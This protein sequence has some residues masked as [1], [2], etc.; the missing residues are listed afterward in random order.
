MK[1]RELVDQVPATYSQIATW[2]NNGVKIG[3]KSKGEGHHKQYDELDVKVATVLS[4]LSPLLGSGKRV[5]A[6]R[7]IMK[8]VATQ[9]RKEPAIAERP[10]IYITS[11]GRIT[12][13]PLE[14]Y[15]IATRK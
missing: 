15:V 6:A 7:D 14:G 1:A 13:E 11:T 3:S 4:S 10:F 12:E 9:I 8:K 2:Q 5:P